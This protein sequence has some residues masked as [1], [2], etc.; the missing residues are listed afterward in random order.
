VYRRKVSGGINATTDA[1]GVVHLVATDQNKSDSGG[2]SPN[3]LY[4]SNSQSS[5]AVSQIGLPGTEKLFGLSLAVSAEAP[6][7]WS[8]ETSSAA[9][10]R[11]V[12]SC[13]TR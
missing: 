13:S 6:S 1:A 11:T 8:S 4:Y 3:Q 10:T 9:C 7:A 2:I 12:R 5:F